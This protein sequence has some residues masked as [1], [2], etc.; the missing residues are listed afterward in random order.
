MNHNLLACREE[1]IR[2]I[3]DYDDDMEE[4]FVLISGNAHG[5]SGAIAKAPSPAKP[6]ASAGSTPAVPSSTSTAVD[7]YYPEP[8]SL[9]G[10]DSEGPWS[11]SNHDDLAGGLHTEGLERTSGENLLFSLQYNSSSSLEDEG[12]FIP[13]ACGRQVAAVGDNQPD[14]S[15][16]LGASG[17]RWE[18]E[19]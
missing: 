1:S 6:L 13:S 4:N 10:G 12:M 16:N 18:Q 8:I 14:P 17:Q 7:E 19:E 5:S 9:G 11:P 2:D 15:D 3:S